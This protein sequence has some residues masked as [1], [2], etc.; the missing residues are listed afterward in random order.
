MPGSIS[1][2]G[3]AALKAGAGLSTC[4]VPESIQPI[5]AGYRP[6]VMVVP[7]PDG[8]SGCLTPEAAEQVLAMLPKYDVLALGPGVTTQP[9][10]REAIKQ[11]LEG[12][13]IPIVLDADGLNCLAE[14]GPLEH[15]APLV[16]TPHPGEM[17]RLMRTTTEAVLDD[18]FGIVE[19][20]GSRFGATIVL[21]GAFS[22]VCQAGHDIA[23][24]L[25]SNP[26]LATAGSGDVLTGAIAALVHQ[27]GA[28]F[29][30]ACVGVFLHGPP[31]ISNSLLL[32][33]PVGDTAMDIAM[34]LSAKRSVILDPERY[35][36]NE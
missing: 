5:V 16:L 23:V 33:T 4:A 20:C 19:K 26:G 29:E 13:Q 34:H 30:A 21:K 8:G 7:L 9:P 32:G 11:I 17:A 35:L 31:V 2:T 12:A 36:D 15:K 10:V 28:P 25:G 27:V 1:L 6:E 3:F 18:R 14:L 22:L 24:N